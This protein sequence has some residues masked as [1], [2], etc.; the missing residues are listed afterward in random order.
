MAEHKTTEGLY[1]PGTYTDTAFIPVPQ[2]S[3][4]LLVHLAQITPGFT[5][6]PKILQDVEFTG[7]ALPVLP[8]PIKAQVFV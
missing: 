1:G 3:Q 8:G 6:D 4:R 7:G 2:D 5:K